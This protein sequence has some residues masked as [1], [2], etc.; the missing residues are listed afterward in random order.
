MRSAWFRR[1]AIV[2][3]ALMTINVSLQAYVAFSSGQPFIG[4]NY[5]NAP[6]GTYLV[7][8]VLVI[9]IPVGIWWAIRN[10]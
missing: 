7:L 8:P 9:G 4:H 2:I 1:T 5:W 10:W 6:I 3:G